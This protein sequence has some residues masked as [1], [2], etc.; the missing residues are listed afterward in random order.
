MNMTEQKIAHVALEN[1]EL[2]TKIIG[3]WTSR[4]HKELD[5]ETIININNQKIKFNTEIKQELRNH[6]LPKILEQAQSFEPLLVI[7]NRIFPTI[8]EELRQHNIAYLETNGNIF[9]KQGNVFLWLDTQKP[10]L[11]EKDKLNRAFS[12]TGLKV[13]FQ[14]LIDKD[15]INLPYRDIAKQTEVGL[16]NINYVFNG[17]KEMNFLVLLNKDEK[18]LN[19]KQALIDKWIT[20]YIE[21]LKPSL[22]LG[23]FR[24]LKEDDFIHWK[25]INLRN[26]QSWWGGEPAGDL[27]TN[28]LQPAELTIYTT[29]SRND[30]IKNYRL[31]PDDNGNVVVY[32]KFWNHYPVNDNLAPPLVVYADLLQKNDRRCTETANKIYDE[33]IQGKI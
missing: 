4:G 14:L 8:K 20:A 21:K 1:L 7:A 15:I 24:F 13:I 28:Y 11:Q 3:K 29:E 33:L 18:L 5:G 25:K 26:Q 10:L 2:N 27:F 31:I 32:K 9:I 6:Q 30:I 22:K 17:L 23:T 12:K 19:N 16:G